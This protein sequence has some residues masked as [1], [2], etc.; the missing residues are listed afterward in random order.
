ML[1]EEYPLPKVPYS[2]QMDFD[3]FLPQLRHPKNSWRPERHTIVNPLNMHN[4]FAI[5]KIPLN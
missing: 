1:E 3:E 4:L 2:L 5:G